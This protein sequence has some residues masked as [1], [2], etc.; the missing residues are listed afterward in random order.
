MLREMGFAKQTDF[1]LGGDFHMQA[2]RLQKPCTVGAQ[3]YSSDV[4]AFLIA[5]RAQIVLEKIKKGVDV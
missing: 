2:I 4:G 3:G 1:S 5:K